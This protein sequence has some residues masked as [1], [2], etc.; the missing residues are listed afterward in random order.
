M[1]ARVGRS[2]CLARLSLVA[3]ALRI[4]TAVSDSSVTFTAKALAYGVPQSSLDKWRQDG[5]C[6]YSNLLFRVASAPGQTDPAKLQK[7][8]EEMEPK[9]TTSV[10]SAV[11]RLLFEAGTFVVSELKSS[12]EPGSVDP[13]RKLSV[14]ERSS[15]LAAMQAKLGAVKITG[16]LEPSHQL[17]DLCSA[18][19][20]DQVIRH[21]P[22]HRCSS[23][24][25]EV[26]LVKRDDTL[27]R[28]EN[29]SLRVAQKQAVIKVDLSSELRLAQALSRRSVAL[30]MAGVASFEQHESY[31]RTLMEHL[32]RQPPPGYQA[33]GIEQVMRADKELWIKVAEKVQH[34]FVGPGGSQK[35]DKAIEEFQFS[36]AVAFHVLPMPKPEKQPYKRTWDEAFPKGK[37]S[38]GKADKGKGKGKWVSQA[39][40]KSQGKPGKGKQTSVPAALKGLDP[41]YK[42]KPV[43]FNH[44]LPHGCSEETW[45]TEDGHM[46]RRGLHL[47]MKC[48]ATDHGASGCDK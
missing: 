24:D 47:C 14:Q 48:H 27:F 40:G 20:A 21:V 38:K 23:R 26:T 44:S 7:L 35:V 22:A 19:T 42:G 9:A 18:M 13:V 30:E 31:V 6:T 41:N 10:A 11:N 43:C 1:A 3:G 37:G 46:C 34:E 39:W 4:M 5:L 2:R 25:Q 45:D 29:T 33:P 28:L 32:H 15:R 16:A 12:L 36:P 17:V 8:L